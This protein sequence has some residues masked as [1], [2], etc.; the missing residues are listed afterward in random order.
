MPRKS[1]PRT[2]MHLGCWFHRWCHPFKVNQKNM[3]MTPSNIFKK[4][5]LMGF[6]HILSVSSMCFIT[7]L[8]CSINCVIAC[9]GTRA[10]LACDARVLI[11]PAIV[12]C[13]SIQFSSY[14]YIYI[15][16]LYIYIYYIIIYP[17]FIF[18]S[19]TSNF[20]QTN[21]ITPPRP[22]VYPILL[23][24][25]SSGLYSKPTENPLPFILQKS[26]SIFVKPCWLNVKIL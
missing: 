7:W 1:L 11:H 21:I 10:T 22:W 14:I 23:I 8:S 5:D 19:K 4:W 12:A 16:I 17:T 6:Y 13:I 2:T 18:T 20:Q 24:F 26:H 9:H 15:Y 25:Q 3:G